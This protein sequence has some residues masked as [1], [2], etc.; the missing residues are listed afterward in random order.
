MRQAATAYSTAMRSTLRRFSSEN[1]AIVIVFTP[2]ALKLQSVITAELE[3]AALG[4]QQQ[5]QVGWV[6]VP[7]SGV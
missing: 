2:L 6:A 1:S 3:I 5:F 4:R 7:L